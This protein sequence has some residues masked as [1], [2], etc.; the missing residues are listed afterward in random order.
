MHGD[1]WQLVIR[2]ETCRVT[3]MDT[4]ECLVVS[5]GRP[6]TSCVAD[7]WRQANDAHQMLAKYI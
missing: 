1:T 4:S 7:G 5:A 3:A 2:C 6:Q